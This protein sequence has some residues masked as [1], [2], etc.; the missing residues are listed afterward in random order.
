MSE[1][2]T[3]K[4]VTTGLATGAGGIAVGALLWRNHRVLGGISGFAIGSNLP[5]LLNEKTRFTALCGIA[6]G[7]AG[8]AGT[9]LLPKRPG[10]GFAIGYL[11]TRVVTYMLGDR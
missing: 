11:G 5:G 1:A 8:I 6:Q 9:R 3:Q 7:G 4:Q 10:L 2:L